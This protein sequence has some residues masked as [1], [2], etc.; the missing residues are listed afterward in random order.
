MTLIFAFKLGDLNTGTGIDRTAPAHFL[1]NSYQEE[2]AKVK[3]F[4]T[5]ILVK[6]YQEEALNPHQPVLRLPFQPLQPTMAH[7]PV[8]FFIDAKVARLSFK[9]GHSMRDSFF[10][11]ISS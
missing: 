1:P 5:S 8:F 4:K 2:P 10:T 9:D 7:N 3:T 6:N 11:V